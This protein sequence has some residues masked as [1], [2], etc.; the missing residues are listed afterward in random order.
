M[1][2]QRLKRAVPGFQE[3][4][5]FSRRGD[6][7][8]ITQAMNDWELIRRYAQSGDDCA[9][10]ELVRRHGPFV[11][12]SARRQL[13]DALA[14]DA[15]QSVFL[16]LA[17]K[18]A[19]LGSN[20]VLSSWLFRTTGFVAAQ[21]RRRE[22]R[23]NRR[24]RET[25]AMLSDAMDKEATDPLREEDGERYLDDALAA[26]SEHERS[27]VLTRFFEGLRFAEVG[28]RFGIG[29]EAAKKRVT[30]AI[31]RMRMHLVRRGVSLSAAALGTLLS[32]PR[33]VALPDALARSIVRAAS[34]HGTAGVTGIGA[35]SGR[36]RDGFDAG[37][38]G[39]F[40]VR[41]GRILGNAAI[42]GATLAVAIATGMLLVGPAEAPGGSK[43]SGGVEADPVAA[44]VLAMRA[45]RDRYA[46]VDPHVSQLELT[47]L[48]DA[49]DQPL[50]GA[51]VIVRRTGNTGITDLPTEVSDH[52]G[53]SVIAVD[54]R[55]LAMLQVTVTSAG[56]VPVHLDWRGY[57]FDRPSL[58][59]TLRLPVAAVLS[60][61]VVDP[62]QRPVPGAKVQVTGPSGFGHGRRESGRSQLELVTD[63]DGRFRSDQA[64]WSRAPAMDPTT[65]RFQQGAALGLLV[66]HPDFAL[67]SIGVEPGSMERDLTIVLDRGALLRGQVTDSEG[68]PI[69]G[70]TVSGNLPTRAEVVTDIEGRF[71]LPHV[72]RGGGLHFVV[73]APGFVEHGVIVLF[74]PTAGW[75]GP[76]PSMPWRPER[77]IYSALPGKGD[78][79][80]KGM[81]LDTVVVLGREEN[82]VAAPPDAVSATAISTRVLGTVIDQETRQAVPAFR[83]LRQGFGTRHLIGE[84]V[85]GRFDWDLGVTSDIERNIEVEADGYFPSLGIGREVESGEGRSTLELTF[86][87]RRS[88]GMSGW[89]ELPNAR[90]AVGARV[91][92]VRSGQGTLNA[93]EGSGEEVLT[94]ADGSFRL[95]VTGGV[96]LVQV[97]H[98]GGWL[99]FPLAP[100]NPTI[101]RLESWGTVEGTLVDAGLPVPDAEVSLR[102]DAASYPGGVVAMNFEHTVRTDAEGRFR[103][104]KVPGFHLRATADGATAQV[105]LIRGKAPEVRLERR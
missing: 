60:G 15:T 81:P 2:G 95:T 56:R 26:L 27:A 103:F 17:R 3:L 52:E 9:F 53:R 5:P 51:E 18:A 101:V 67:H 37:L 71:D 48:D 54:P 88:A 78:S 79:I 25:A 75:G 42:G 105:I 13:G 98:P 35:V 21:I 36:I 58:R 100:G 34:G 43:G 91:A 50:P 74:P 104:E 102:P 84:G 12:A 11:Y 97:S 44:T 45:R 24:E 1:R 46:T 19:G 90:P 66:D 89:V 38:A 39:W 32:G 40:R 22:A 80:E 4:S 10:A 93:G 99:V 59:H 72:S 55:G 94:G 8:G 7:R 73:V 14:G 33:A 20:V 77:A 49:T 87:L 47:V 69:H 41:L 85:N 70:A 31:E 61:V 62:Q 65:G 63:R 83:V 82:F 6:K 30:R 23:R 57:E 28:V 64:P 16:V 86:E 92:P 76:P 96:P 68:T 29:E